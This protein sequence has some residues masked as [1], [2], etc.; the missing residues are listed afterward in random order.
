MK[1]K[2]NLVIG[3]TVLLCSF[4]CSK[5]EQKTTASIPEPNLSTP[6][7]IIDSHIHYRATDE[8]EKSFLEIFEKWNAIGCI[9]VNMRNLER[10]IK[11]AGDHPDR[12]IPYAAI[13]IDSPTVI[14]DIQK[15]YDMGYKGLGELFATNEW[16]YDDP[17]YDPIWALAEKLRL[18]TA[19]HTGIRASAQIVSYFGSS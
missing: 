17:K 16:N 8:W 2:I 6:G 13:E 7:F 10:G 5:Q 4:G 11:F 14:E 1:K 3:L 18:P 12:V 9:L 15:A 19:P